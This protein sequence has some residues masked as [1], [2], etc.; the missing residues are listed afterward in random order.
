MTTE[1][2]IQPGCTVYF[3][4]RGAT[5]GRVTGILAETGRLRVEVPPRPGQTE[6]TETILHPDEVLGF[7]PARA[8]R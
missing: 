3:D 2:T 1:T 8:E 7:S 4:R 5:R 6:P